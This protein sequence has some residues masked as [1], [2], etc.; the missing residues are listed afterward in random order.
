MFIIMLFFPLMGCNGGSSGSGSE[1]DNGTDDRVVESDPEKTQQVRRFV[2]DLKIWQD[3]IRLSPGEKSFDGVG[4]AAAKTATQEVTEMLQAV[5]V[6]GRQA[7]LVALPELFLK[8]SCDKLDFV[9]G[10]VC[11]QLIAGKTLSEL[12]SST[13]DLE[14]FGR[15]LCDLLNEINWPVDASEAFSGN[16]LSTRFALLDGSAELSGHDTGTDITLEVQ[17]TES[18]FMDNQVFFSVTGLVKQG[19]S[20]LTITTGTFNYYFESL[21]GETFQLPLSMEYQLQVASEAL[22]DNAIAGF[23][24][25]IEGTIDFDNGKPFQEL[26]GW[27]KS[28]LVFSAS[29]EFTSALDKLYSTEL[30]VDNSQAIAIQLALQVQSADLNDTADVV[31]GDDLD[32]NQ[33]EPFNFT[34]SW[35]NKHYQVTHSKED[36]D[37]V[38]VSNH[39]D[40]IMSLDYGQSG[41]QVGDIIIG[42]ETYG[43]VSFLN[44]SLLINLPDGTELV[45]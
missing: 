30:I 45:L 24:G 6:A 7:T 34:I 29:G 2:D 42:D 1:G 14:L 21:D 27:D 20:E 23:E 9:S 15:P 22:A 5:A 10:Y 31:Y 39:E 37:E 17:L 8:N 41:G 44:G 19:D 28:P 11:H 40:V 35:D 33:Q 18:G 25:S 12:C 32:V 38:T 4:E 3:A 26:I 36:A 43:K 13:L 16:S